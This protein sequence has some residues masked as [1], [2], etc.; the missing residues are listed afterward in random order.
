MSLSPHDIAIRWF[1]EVWNKG[2]LEAVDE[3][4]TPD[5][6]SYGFPQPESVLD[7]EGYKEYVLEFRRSF[8]HV[9]LSV[10]ETVA[11]DE[12]RRGALDGNDAAH[13]LR[14]RLPAHG[15]DSEC[16]RHVADAPSWRTDL[17]RMECS[18]SRQHCP[19][20]ERS[21]GAI[22]VESAAGRRSTCAVTWRASIK[23]LAARHRDICFVCNTSCCRLPMDF[24]VQGFPPQ[25]PVVFRRLSGS[26]TGQRPRGRSNF[27]RKQLLTAAFASIFAI[28]TAAGA[29]VYVRVGPPPPR[30][31]VMPAAAP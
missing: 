29:Q 5:A 11:E 17:R 16:S 1:E 10:D 9:H 14:S 25:L 13:G 20:P 4:A 8:T 6:K 18:R 31:E 28:A 30:H 27:M 12:P 26:R 21:L 24:P 2:R 23:L 7:R 15:K 22:A 3:L 19:L